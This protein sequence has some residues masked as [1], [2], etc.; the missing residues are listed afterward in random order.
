MGEGHD[1]SLGKSQ[2][3]PLPELPG[4]PISYPWGTTLHQLPKNLGGHSAAL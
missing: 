3:L 2:H 1:G 4:T